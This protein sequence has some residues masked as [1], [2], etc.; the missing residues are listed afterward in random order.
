MI[1]Q[2]PH[3]PQTQDPRPQT[4]PVWSAPAIADAVHAGLLERAEADDAEQAVY[5]FDVLDELRLHPILHEALRAAG[6]GVHPEQRYPSHARRRSK[7]EGKRCDIVLTPDGRPL[8]NL[9]VKDTLFDDPS[10]VDP[11]KAYW[12]EVKTVAQHEPQGPFTRYAAELLSTVAQDVKKLWGDP[13]IRHAGLLLVLFTEDQRV[14]EHD[15]DVWHRRCIE[16]GFPLGKP[17]VRNL[18]LCDRTGNGW[19]AAALFAVRD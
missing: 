5:G 4:L 9:L 10:A 15:L 11:Q 17:H 12:L 2:L 1:D 18:A 7:A 13:L 14:A 16:R 6:Y 8:R 19:C 3:R